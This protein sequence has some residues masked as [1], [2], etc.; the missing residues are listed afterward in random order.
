MN[1]P[2]LDVKKMQEPIRD[3]LADT[4]LEVLDSGSYING[5]YV[6]QFEKELAE[7]NQVKNA[8]GVTSGSDALIISLMAFGIGPGDEVI[9]S[10]FTFFATVGA[11]SRVGATPV[12]VDIC[13]DSYQ[14]DHRLVEEKITKKTKCIIP[15]SLFGQTADMDPLLQIAEKYELRVLEDAAQSIGAEYKGKKSGSM[16]DAGIFS[17]FPAKN[18][19]CLGDA[20]AV[21]TNDDE[22]AVKLKTMRNHGGLSLYHYDHIGGNFRLDAIQAAI[23]STKL[24]HLKTWEEARRTNAAYY[25]GRFA[26]TNGMNSPMEMDYAHHVY[27]QYVLRI[28]D[29]KRDAVQAHLKEKN[30]ASAVYYPLC[31]HQQKCFEY[32]GYGVGDFPVAE[33]AALEVLAIPL[34]TDHRELVADSILEALQHV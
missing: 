24:P 34:L 28:H 23:L 29:G 11:I 33:K 21:C 31:L 25:K 13:E 27:N 7:Y 20:G 19:G 26:N 6:D 30:I 2:M 12:F 32:L 18:L 5:P 8:I 10:P 17:F 15:V 1:I 22:L 3:A 9:T 14:I 4:L 16:G